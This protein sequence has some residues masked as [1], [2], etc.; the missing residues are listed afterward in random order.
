[1]AEQVNVVC[2]KWGRKYP[3]AYVNRLFGMVRRSLSRPHRFVCLTDDASGLRREVEARPLPEPNLKGW[4][5]KLGLFKPKV[6]D[7]S[8]RTLFLDLDTVVVD[9][10]D[11]FF[12]SEAD[13]QIIRDWT[14]ADPDVNSSVFRITIGTYPQIWEIFRQDPSRVIE[15]YH[16]DQDWIAHMIP[17]APAWPDG[18]VVSYKKHCETL[19]TEG[20]SVIPQGAR[21]VAFHGVPKPHHVIHDPWQGYRHAPWIAEFWRE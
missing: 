18:W 14:P 11:P 8:G 1:M 13:F 21:I 2:I 12:E 5:H 16:G 4:W 15:H 17:C 6:Y 9:A 3:S 10:L 7:L 20:T 19:G